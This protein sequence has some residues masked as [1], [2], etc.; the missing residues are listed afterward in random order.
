MTLAATLQEQDTNIAEKLNHIAY[1]L[2]QTNP[3]ITDIIGEF[4]GLAMYLGATH[5]KKIITEQL[6]LMSIS[7]S[8]NI[9]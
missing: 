8:P 6:A 1:I 2:E 5:H 3:P 7:T 4:M 9:N